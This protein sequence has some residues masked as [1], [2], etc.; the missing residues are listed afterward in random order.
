MKRFGYLGSG[1]SDSEALFTEAAVVSAL[2]KVQ[3]FAGIRPTGR[4]LFKTFFFFVN[5]EERIS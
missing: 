3:Q 2:A 5:Y 1:P 4:K